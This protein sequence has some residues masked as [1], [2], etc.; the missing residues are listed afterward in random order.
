MASG[1]GPRKAGSGALASLRAAEQEEAAFARL[2]AG[3]RPG[4]A[5]VLPEAGISAAPLTAAKTASSAP[6]SGGLNP[7]L[8]N[9]NLIGQNRIECRPK[10]ARER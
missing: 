4:S 7:N 8:R 2:I 6:A 1:R 9:A 3:L 5:P 10:N